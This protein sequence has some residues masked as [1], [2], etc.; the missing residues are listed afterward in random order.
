M[1]NSRGLHAPE[2]ACTTCKS[3][4]PNVLYELHAPY[5]SNFNTSTL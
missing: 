1:L 5:E 2:A 3:H 4:I